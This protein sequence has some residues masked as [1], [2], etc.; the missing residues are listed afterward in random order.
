MD[1]PSNAS[2]LFE[3]PAARRPSDNTDF[4]G[5]M[6]PLTTVGGIDGGD[7][8]TG[9]ARRP[10]GSTGATRRAR[11]SS[12]AATAV[13]NAAAAAYRKVSGRRLK[14]RR[15]TIIVIS[16]RRESQADRPELSEVISMSKEDAELLEGAFAAADSN[17][18]GKLQPVEVARLV[19]LLSTVGR[20]K[21]RK[22]ILERVF[23]SPDDDDD[24]DEQQSCGQQPPR[25]RTTD[26]SKV[27]FL[28]IASAMLGGSEANRLRKT[29]TEIKR[30]K[31]LFDFC[32][33]NNSKTLEWQEIKAVMR[34]L[35]E[36]SCNDAD[37][38]QAI[39][40]TPDVLNPKDPE[41]REPRAERSTRGLDFG[42]RGGQDLPPQRTRKDEEEVSFHP[43]PSE[44]GVETSI[45]VSSSAW[46][47]PN[48]LT[49]GMAERQ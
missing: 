17:G 40:A 1:V 22:Q 37:A 20:S 32:D 8:E 48:G 29:F 28:E 38:I 21:K 49:N 24:D 14:F 19:R 15:K 36:S 31:G 27:E 26:I 2:A 30:I 11:G 18:D 39:V 43:I 44:G 13:Y 23:L 41:Q 10:R 6:N 12:S 35:G 42:A 7:V 33:I 3:I 25:Q 4:R 16:A 45:L 34:Q 5:T 46:N 47:W 9:A